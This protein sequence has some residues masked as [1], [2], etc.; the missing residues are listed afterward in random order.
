MPL[1]A[2]K[3]V[4]AVARLATVLAACAVV[5]CGGRVSSAV[6]TDASSVTPTS[7][8]FCSLL[9]EALCEPLVACCSGV[10][11]SSCRV[12]YSGYCEQQ[13][14]PNPDGN[15]DV[16]A[17]SQCLA[18][19]TARHD[20]CKSLT[21]HESAAVAGLSDVCGRV[22]RGGVGPGGPCS[23]TADCAEVPGATSACLD[24]LCYAS[25]VVPQGAACETTSVVCAPDLVCVWNLSATCVAPIAEGATCSN[26]V[27]GVPCAFGLFCQS[28]GQP[29][30]TCVRLKE[31]G[32][33]CVVS[34]ECLG[35]CQAGV[36]SHVSVCTPTD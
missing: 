27:S 22:W 32:A 16:S 33:R 10:D 15:F 5:A 30:G 3:R 2:M 35:V 4:S 28:S 26:S 34:D 12:G 7:G 23:A 17:A 31:D 8:T 25:R 14:H 18:Y 11:A 9:A 19:E 13:L 20:G 24:N 29:L 6:A 1:V 36:C 21:R